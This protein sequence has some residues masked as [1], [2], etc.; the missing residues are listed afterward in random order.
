MNSGAVLHIP[1]VWPGR[2]DIVGKDGGRRGMMIR[3]LCSA[4]QP[5]EQRRLTEEGGGLC[6]SQRRTGSS[7][8]RSASLATGQNDG[9]KL[10]LTAHEAVLDEIP[11]NCRFVRGIQNKS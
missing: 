6:G 4:P 5:L 3:A 8:P 2:I 10:S 7:L 1:C 9:E 11:V